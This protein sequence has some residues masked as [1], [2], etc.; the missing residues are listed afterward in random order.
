MSTKQPSSRS[1]V[2]LRAMAT[3]ACPLCGRNDS[4]SFTSR[5][6]DGRSLST[7]ICRDCGFVWVNPSPDDQALRKY[8]AW[9]YRREAKGTPMRTLRQVYRAAEGAAA[10]YD[11]IRPFLVPNAPVLDAGCGGGELV[12]LLRQFGV[13]ARGIEPDETYS[14]FAREELRLPVETAFLQDVPFADEAFQ[15]VLLYHVLEHVA[16][17]AAILSLIRPWLRRGGVLVVEVPN[18]E[19]RCEAPISRFHHDHLSYFTPRTLSG[20]VASSGLAPE[21]VSLSPDRGNVFVL[22]RREDQHSPIELSGEYGQIRGLFGA[23]PAMN[24]YFSRLPFQRMINR[25]NRYI[26]TGW[27]SKRFTR[28]AD[29]LDAQAA[30]IR[31][32]HDAPEPAELEPRP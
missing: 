15:M 27:A 6:R 24:F 21:H 5:A 13:D 8:Y 19:S 7:T 3:T 11:V 9:T 17:P 12:Y 29:V 30:A 10:R 31:R 1:E 32:R 16:Q 28:A 18:L 14:A 4:E 25:A 2:R 23:R 20:L 26:R 22:A